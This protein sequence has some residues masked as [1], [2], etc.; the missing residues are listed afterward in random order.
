MTEPAPDFL[1]AM[2]DAQRRPPV[3]PDPVPVP[4]P[5]ATADDQGQQTPPVSATATVRSAAPDDWL[6]ALGRAK[7]NRTA[8]GDELSNIISERPA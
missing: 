8:V 2:R 1:R 5:V 4:V 6:R 7:R 3:E